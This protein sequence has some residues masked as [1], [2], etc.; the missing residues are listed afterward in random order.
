MVQIVT[1]AWMVNKK[2]KNY[3]LLCKAKAQPVTPW[4]EEPGLGQWWRADP[5]TAYGEWLRFRLE[6]GTGTVSGYPG[7]LHRVPNLQ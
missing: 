6:P 2:Y 5:W 1:I 7:A 3:F 4:A